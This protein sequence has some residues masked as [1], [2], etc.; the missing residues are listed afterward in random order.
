[1]TLDVTSDSGLSAF[2]FDN[3]SSVS[4]SPVI[5]PPPL[6]WVRSPSPHLRPD[7][8]WLSA[9][10]SQ[11]PSLPPPH[12]SIRR[13]PLLTSP[14][15]QFS[16]PLNLIAPRVQDYPSALRWSPNQCHVESNG[17]VTIT[18]AESPPSVLA[19]EMP[20]QPKRR[21]KNIDCKQSI[22]EHHIWNIK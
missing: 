6:E 13:S 12:G 14:I 17:T 16:Q 2:T 22:S 19:D 10:A 7:S 11:P 3:D 20:L 15:R 8:L 9:T 1:M 18:G 21:G 4:P 5:L